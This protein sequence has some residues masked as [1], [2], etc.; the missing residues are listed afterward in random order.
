MIPALS[1][2]AALHG[3]RGRLT[4]PFARGA[5][6]L[7]LTLT[8]GATPAEAGVA[9]YG[10]DEHRAL[11]G[12]TPLATYVVRALK[13]AAVTTLEVQGTDPGSG[14]FTVLVDVTGLGEGDSVNVPLPTGSGA[15]AR[16]TALHEIGSSA[17]GT[18]ADRWQ[19]TALL[20]TSARLLWVLSAERDRLTRLAREVAAQRTVAGTVGAGLDLVGADLA[21]P[22]FPPTPYSVDDDTV[23]LFHLDDAPGATPAIADAA[24]ILP[25][26]TPHHGTPSGAVTL[27]AQGRYDRGVHFTGP[28]AVTVAAHTDFNVG[29]GKGLTV[30]LFVRPDAGSTL[31]TVARRGDVA[32]PTWSLEV[33]ELGLGGRHSVRAKVNDGAVILSVAAAVELATD[34]FSHVA[35]VLARTGG[36]ARLSVVVDGL[37][38]GSVTGALG[39]LTGGSVLLG[40]DTS[41]FRG[42]IDEVRIS[43]AAR[44]HFHPTLGES[45]ESYRRRLALFRRWELPIPAGLQA[46]LNRLLPQ[47]GGV[48]HPFIVDDTD[49]PA[50]SGGV[51]LRVWPVAL[52]PME[53]IDGDGRPGVDESTMSP[54]GDGAA[55]PALLGRCTDPRVT[56]AAVVPDPARTPGLPDP[57]PRLMRPTAAAALTRLVDLFDAAGV[58]GAF[59]VQ[60]GWDVAVVDAR[61]DGRALVLTSTVVSTGR[62]AAFAHRAGFDFVEHRADRTVYAAVAPGRPVL[63]GPAGAGP[64][65]QAGGT[66][67]LEVGTPVTVEVSLGTPT[68]TGAPLAPD[69]EVRF[70]LLGAGGRATLA[71]ATPGAHT[72]TLTATAPGPLAISADIVLRGRTT[73]V[74]VT[75]QVLPTQLADG[76]SI[77]ADGTTGVQLTDV[78]PPIAGFDAAYLATVT[79]PRVVLGPNPQDAQLDRGLV[80]PLLAL[81]D[82]F[83]AAGQ[84]GQLTIAQAYRPGAP[85]GDLSREGRRVVLTHS[86]LGAGRLGVA[87][88]AAGF[89]YVARSG[90]TVVV[91]GPPGDPIG[92]DGDLELEV[93]SSITLSVAPAP[94][95]V[96]PTT[97]LG[98]SSSQV[99][100]TAPDQ[101]GVQLMSTTAPSVAVTGKVPGRTWVRATLREAGAAGPYA[102]EVRLRP[103]LVGARISRDQYYLVMNAL[104]TLHPVGVEVLTEQL[105]S[106]VVEL[107]STP[108]GIDPSFTYPA[109]RLHRAVRSLRKETSHG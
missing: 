40:P 71:S 49:A 105:R 20:G 55:D 100:P 84:A 107:S 18:A 106:A 12:I 69:A 77:A 83:D 86:V 59:R 13:A 38:Q 109:F 1:P 9:A 68:F 7:D 29:A 65:L 15:G 97:R 14:P 60:S 54:P 23:A 56:F 45:D 8:A 66:P 72:V 102:F 63:L 48:T 104:H 82:A 89:P 95:A 64:V 47:I 6:A 79:D 44:A 3:M 42:I 34:R 101:Q 46:V 94:G 35:L 67:V 10:F 108:G 31:G 87:A 98:W 96:S 24:A 61:A 53:S 11:Y 93:G 52:A 80:G 25:G 62:L 41:G 33:G 5:D 4:L 90:A 99:V 36:T 16:L 91:A 78:P 27:G 32:N 103:E 92:V 22:R 50:R 19:V 43:G 21:V 88:H 2:P 57:D 85:V 37:E 75:V 70:S 73:T 58:P 51:M 26:R 28:G 39:T 74:T 17:A 76:A 81:L 30:E